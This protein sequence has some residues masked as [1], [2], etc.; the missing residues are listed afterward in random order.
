[1]PDSI[2]QSRDSDASEP[3]EV[4]EQSPEA[5]Y[6]N[7]MRS[8]VLMSALLSVFF[9]FLLAAILSPGLIAGKVHPAPLAEVILGSLVGSF[10]AMMVIAVPVSLDSVREWRPLRIT[11]VEG[12]VFVETPGQTV[13]L[14]MAD[15]TWRVVNGVFSDRVGMHNSR[16]PLILLSIRRSRARIP[17]QRFSFACGFTD[18]AFSMWSDYLKASGVVRQPDVSGWD[19]VIRL[20]FSGSI[21]LT[22]GAGL[23]LLF[24]WQIGPGTIPP[25]FA[26]LGAAGGLAAGRLW[27][28]FQSQDRDEFLT[29]IDRPPG[30]LARSGLAA[31]ALATASVK[32][33][34]TAIVSIAVAGFLIA[35]VFQQWLRGKAETRF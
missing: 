30:I 5:G 16:R 35:Y 31:T 14:P 7:L 4:I 19:A 17:R 13:C 8:A 33:S 25:P 34:A 3:D 1:M 21:G 23:E 11:A 28:Q 2:R 12:N 29:L 20:A 9:T 18:Q 6:A 24:R 15:C 26:F 27:H 32:G 10:I 22:V